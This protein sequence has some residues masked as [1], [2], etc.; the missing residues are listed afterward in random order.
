VPDET[1]PDPEPSPHAAPGGT[2]IPRRDCKPPAGQR[3][4][5]P[6]SR[7]GEARH[8]VGGVVATCGLGVLWVGLQTVSPLAFF[9]ARAIARPPSAWLS[10]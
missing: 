7:G 1:R 5:Q 3:R 9:T 6:S 2:L 10:R 4:Q 8:A